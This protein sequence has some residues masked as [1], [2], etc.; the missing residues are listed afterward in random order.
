MS[1]SKGDFFGKNTSDSIPPLSPHWHSFIYSP[2]PFSSPSLILLLDICFT[3]SKVNTV[4]CSS[5]YPQEVNCKK[6]CCFSIPD[7]YCTV[8]FSNKDYIVYIGHFPTFYVIK[9]TRMTNGDYYDK[10]QQMDNSIPSKSHLLSH[11]L[12]YLLKQ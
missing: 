9:S 5:L 3:M 1:P 6:L 12:R 2:F 8:K 7:K 10:V 4:F 11:Q